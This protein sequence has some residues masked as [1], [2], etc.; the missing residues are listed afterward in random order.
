MKALRAPERAHLELLCAQLGRD[1]AVGEHRP[2]SGL[3]DERDDDSGP[4][5]HS[6]SNDVDAPPLQLLRGE[7]AGGVGRE[8]A[9]EAGRGAE[10]CRPRR[11]VRSLAAGTDLG[12]RRRLGVRLGGAVHPHD[13]I[14]Q[15]VAE[16]DEREGHT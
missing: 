11:D 5:R 10:L 8:L 7:L 6:R 3:V 4:P 14:E 15:Q 1:S 13:H 16:T 2:L 9:D 12:L